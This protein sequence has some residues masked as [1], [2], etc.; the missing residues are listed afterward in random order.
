[1]YKLISCLLLT[2]LFVPAYVF[3]GEGAKGENT[4]PRIDPMQEGKVKSKDNDVAVKLKIRN[5]C[6]SQIN[7]HWLDEETGDRVFYKIIY[8]DTEVVQQTWADHYWIILDVKEKPLGIYRTNGKD[9][10]VTIENILPRINPEKEGKVKSKG[11]PVAVSITVRNLTKSEISLHWL[12][13][14]A[15]DR[16]HYKDIKA[17]GEVLQGTFQGHY[18]IVLDK[19]DKPLGIYKVPDKDGVIAVEDSSRI[20]VELEDGVMEDAGADDEHT[21]FTGTGFANFHGVQGASVE[22]TAMVSTPGTYKMIIRYANG[23]FENRSL[24]I[25]V[26]GKVAV[27]KLEFKGTGDENWALY[28]TITVKDVKFKA[29][30]NVIKLITIDEDGPNLDSITIEK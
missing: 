7:L 19:N 6:G 27:D 17:G 5:R 29:G 20:V 10:V 9:S 28:R 4:L 26:N 14:D 15:G 2:V 16:A 18:W 11:T 25:L 1:M 30:K 22:S 3:A 8:E 12:D 23:S 24:K 21:G 13:E